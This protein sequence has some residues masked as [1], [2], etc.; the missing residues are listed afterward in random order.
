M[1]SRDRKVMLPVYKALIR[2]HLELCVQLWNPPPEYGNWSLILRIEGVQRRFT[3][4]IDG[5]GQL[6]YSERLDI[7]KLTTLAER[8]FRGD[9]IEVFKAKSKLS[10]INGV[11]NFGRSGLN[12]VSSMNAYN[13]SAK[14]R[15]IKRNFINLK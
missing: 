3:R 4:M 13:S 10:N 2:P 8:R 9:L 5:L 12:L 15:N 11:F 1:I 6:L 7:L 14:V